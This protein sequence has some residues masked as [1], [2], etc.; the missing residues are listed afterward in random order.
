[1]GLRMSVGIT[2]GVGTCVVMGMGRAMAMAMAMGVVTHE[3]KTISGQWRRFYGF[4]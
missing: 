4:Y 2:M 3:A 1:M